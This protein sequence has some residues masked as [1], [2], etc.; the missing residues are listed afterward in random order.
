MVGSRRAALPPTPACCGACARMRLIGRMRLTVARPRPTAARS[1]SMTTLRGERRLGCRCALL[2]AAIDTTPTARN[3]RSSTS[4]C[5]TNREL[6]ACCTYR[7]PTQRPHPRR[8]RSTTSTSIGFDPAPSW[9]VGDAEP[10][11][12]AWRTAVA[13]TPW[14]VG[15]GEPARGAPC[16]SGGLR[17]F[18]LPDL[19]RHLS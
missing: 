8:R 3:L 4:R 2:V 5:L 15:G 12:A 13:A 17:P 11:E 19:G 16:Q 18:V 14:L 9:D 6:P 1:E 10:E 7:Q